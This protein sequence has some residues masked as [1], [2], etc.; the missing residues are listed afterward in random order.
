MSD[1]LIIKTNHR[2]PQGSFMNC[3]EC[4]LAEAFKETYPQYEDVQAGT[5]SITN[6]GEFIATINPPFEF[7]DFLNLSE[8]IEFETEIKFLK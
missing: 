2:K 7:T 5:H 6:R 8:G 3:R 4:P 1:K